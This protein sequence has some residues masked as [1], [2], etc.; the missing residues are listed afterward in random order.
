[1]KMKLKVTEQGVLIPKELLGELEEVEI[2]QTQGKII[3]AGVKS[4]PSIWHL[5]ANPVEC[6]V[7]DL[8]EKHDIYING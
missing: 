1:M 2:V 3:I 8:G 5:G 6:D 7:T 4:T